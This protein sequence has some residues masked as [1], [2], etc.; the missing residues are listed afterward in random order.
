[1]INTRAHALCDYLLGI[2]LVAAPALFDFSA[3]SAGYVACLAA[4][5]LLWVLAATTTFEYSLLKLVPLKVHLWTDLLTGVLLSASPFIWDF[6]EE[7]FKPHLVFGL[8][9]SM[10]SALTDRVLHKDLKK[11]RAPA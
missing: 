9:V 8:T 6:Y 4:A 1:M 10:V 5:G 11:A 2:V 7:V 3:S